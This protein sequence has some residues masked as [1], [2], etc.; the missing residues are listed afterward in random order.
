MTKPNPAGDQIAFRGELNSAELSKA[1]AQ[2]C[3]PLFPRHGVDVSIAETQ[4]LYHRIENF[5]GEILAKS[6]RQQFGTMAKFGESVAQAALKAAVAGHFRKAVICHIR[7]AT[8]FKNGAAYAKFGY[9]VAL[10]KE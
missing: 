7:L 4:G 3:V 1:V 9:K 5:E 2:A 6:L 8:F 10:L